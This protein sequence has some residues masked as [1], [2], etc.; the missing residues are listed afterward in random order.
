MQGS[1]DQAPEQSRDLRHDM[2]MEEVAARDSY[3]AR[4]TETKTRRSSH[5][6]V[7]VVYSMLGPCSIRFHL[8]QLAIVRISISHPK[9]LFLIFSVL[10][11]FN[12]L[13]CIDEVSFHA[14]QL[15]DHVQ[16]FTHI[17][18][19]SFEIALFQESTCE[20]SRSDQGTSTL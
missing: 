5:G 1:T 10:R 9:W 18:H 12:R 17:P 3:L 20:V 4:D 7:C 15:R 6:M 19:G 13:Y 2:S 11:G 16:T 14:L 8:G